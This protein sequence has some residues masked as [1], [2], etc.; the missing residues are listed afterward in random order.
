MSMG[1][2]NTTEPVLSTLTWAPPAFGGVSN[3]YGE[4]QHTE[5]VLS[6]FNTGN[7]PLGDKG[8]FSVLNWLRNA[9]NDLKVM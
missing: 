7:L 6:T 5:P 9:S 2:F 4:I 8:S 1:R 3:E